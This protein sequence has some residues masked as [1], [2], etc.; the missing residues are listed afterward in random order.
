MVKVAPHACITYCE[1]FITS[2]NEVGHA[3][4]FCYAVLAIIS[5][6]DLPIDVME[7]NQE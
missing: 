6:R 2:M 5:I 7:M 4:L 1:F 3:Y